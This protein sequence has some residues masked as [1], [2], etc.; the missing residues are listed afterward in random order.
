MAHVDCLFVLKLESAIKHGI[1]QTKPYG[2]VYR[3][4]TSVW[5]PWHLLH[6]HIVMC[7]W[8]RMERR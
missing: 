1:N 6:G 7:G 5:L 3:V 4:G 8:F 2:Y